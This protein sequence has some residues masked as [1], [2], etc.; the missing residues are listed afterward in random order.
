MKIAG[1]DI[2]RGWLGN[3]M[4]P[5]DLW[6]RWLHSDA[7]RRFETGRMD[8]SA[9]AIGVTEE[10]ALPVPPDQ[11]LRSFADW[12]M[13]L[14]PG[15]AGMLSRIP[16]AYR[17]AVLS[18]SN[19]LHW[20]RIICDLDLGSLIPSHFVSHLTGRIKPDGEAFAQ[21]TGTLACLP[22]EVLFLD[23]NRLNVDAAERF[24]MHAVRVQG[25]AEAHHALI[26]FG[27]LGDG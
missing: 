18:N 12:P 2:M 6:H 17:C 13:E 11:F 24:G 21:V 10:F 3:R 27:I 19:A 4:T 25:S 5:E 1:I 8:A 16:D 22:E 20:P 14:F 26:E 23:D 9:F 15:T 7:V